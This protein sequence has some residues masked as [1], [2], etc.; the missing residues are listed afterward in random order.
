MTKKKEETIMAQSEIRGS[1]KAGLSPKEKQELDESLRAIYRFCQSEIVRDIGDGGYAEARIP[2]G[3]G[4][5]ALFR[6][7]GN[8]AVSYR[9]EKRW[10][11]FSDSYGDYEDDSIFGR[12]ELAIPVVM[13]WRE[14]LDALLSGTEQIGREK[15]RIRGFSPWN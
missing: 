15:A 2:K 7:Y 3:D 9:P 14:I 4:N 5:P 6:V 10:Y 13:C 8:G 11:Y 1:H 12:A